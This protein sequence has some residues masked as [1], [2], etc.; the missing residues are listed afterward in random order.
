MIQ[1]LTIERNVRIPELPPEISDRSS[2]FARRFTR[3]CRTPMDQR[4]AST[5]RLEGR[6]R[7]LLNLRSRLQGSVAHTEDVLNSSH[8]DATNASP[9]EADYAG[10]IVEQEVALSLLGSATGTLE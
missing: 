9:D 4:P 3:E 1:A 7:S 8:V 2:P 6:R 10:E 5:S